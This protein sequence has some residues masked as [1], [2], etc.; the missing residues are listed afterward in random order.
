VQTPVTRDRWLW[1]GPAGEIRLPGVLMPPL[2]R[3]HGAYVVSLGDVC[4]W[5]AGK[6]EALGVEI[7]PGFAAAETLYDETGAVAGVAT[8]DRGIGR[9][10]EPKAGFQ[11]GME[12]NARYTLI[13]EG[14]RG[15]LAKQLIARFGL[16]EGH[17][18]QKFG[19]G[20]KELWQ[21]A[22]EKHRPGLVQHSFGCRW[23]TARAAARS[24]ITSATIWCRL[25]SSSTSTTPTR[26]CRRSPSSSASRPTPRSGRCW[27]GVAGLPMARGRSA[28]AAGSLCRSSH[29]RAAR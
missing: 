17:E 11:R 6:A 28:R 27:K 4:R 18:P 13:G 21:V 2:M 12:L 1:L 23:T 22:P 25:A 3:N 26:I 10:G 15:W 19:I 8:G 24:S 9:D 7:F 29:F 16:S 14:A 5:L 20:L